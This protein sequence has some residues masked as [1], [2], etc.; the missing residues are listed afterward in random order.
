V[1]AAAVSGVRIGVVELNP[2]RSM[3]RRTGAHAATPEEDVWEEEDAGG[4]RR[5]PSP[6][7]R[8][9]ATAPCVDY[10]KERSS[11]T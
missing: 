11:G 10:E 3:R 6:W 5:W 2:C 1:R 4:R 7:G 9:V 8:G